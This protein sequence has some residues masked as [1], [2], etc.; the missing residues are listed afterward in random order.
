MIEG[1]ILDVFVAGLILEEPVFVPST[2]IHTA[3]LS[4]GGVLFWKG[5]IPDFIVGIY[6]CN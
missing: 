6:L 2:Y 1:K 4:I 5:S 3:L